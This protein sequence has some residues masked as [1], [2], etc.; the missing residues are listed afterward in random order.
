MGSWRLQG[1]ERFVVPLMA[2]VVVLGGVGAWKA[3]VFDSGDGGP[4][5]GRRPDSP[6]M[7]QLAAA[8]YEAGDCVT[9]GS[10]VSLG[11]IDTDVVPCTEGHRIQI[12][13]QVPL[14][15]DGGE[16]PP[17]E[18]WGFLLEALCRPAAER[19]LGVPLDPYGRFYADAIRP[20]EAGWAAGESSMWCGIASAGPPDG[21]GG[22]RDGEAL[23][24]EDARGADQAFHYPPGS[25]VATPPEASPVVVP[26]GDGHHMEVVGEIDLSDRPELPVGSQ[27]RALFDDCAAQSSTYLGA[28]PAAPWQIGTETLTPESWA[29]GSRVVH[30]FLGQWD[31]EQ[32]LIE[33]T[34]SAKG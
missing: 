4:S 19:L 21:S 25:C 8:D 13:E 23:S 12:T 24:T 34:G 22:A 2:L 18:E 20:G 3:G 29:A 32:E 10:G 16:Y 14:E 11:Q 5:D 28:D 17:G 30:C 26:C 27:E 33:V 31:A 15:N 7:E 1:R 6:V 9:W